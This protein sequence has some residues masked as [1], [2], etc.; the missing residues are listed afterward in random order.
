MR[1]AAPPCMKN[2]ATLAVTL[3]KA[4]RSAGRIVLGKR[5]RS[6]RRRRATVSAPFNL[7]PPKG[8]GLVL[9]L[10]LGLGSRV[11]YGATC[12]R[13]FEQK[14]LHEFICKLVL[15]LEVPP[16]FFIRL[17]YVAGGRA[18]VNANTTPS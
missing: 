9:G 2:R 16:S 18:A 4:G 1:I 14:V 15:Q 12:N 6:T 3:A 13:E 5:Y 11:G 7:E 10:G 8:L 17:Q